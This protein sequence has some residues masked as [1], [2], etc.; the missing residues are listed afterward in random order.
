MCSNY[1]FLI[2]GLIIVLIGV[3]LVIIGFVCFYNVDKNCSEFFMLVK[4]IVL[5]LIRILCDF[6]SEVICVGLFV[7]LEEV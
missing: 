2:L 4:S 6:F 1:F 7:L 5:K 3:L